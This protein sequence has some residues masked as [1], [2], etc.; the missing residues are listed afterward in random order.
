MELIASE[1]E[2]SAVNK[3]DLETAKAW[4]VTKNTHQ[5]RLSTFQHTSR[6][7]HVKSILPWTEM[8][9]KAREQFCDLIR[10]RLPI[11]PMVKI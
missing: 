10:K 2:G 8:H 4:G 6:S 11:Q 3:V 7:G 5:P 9:R 1:N